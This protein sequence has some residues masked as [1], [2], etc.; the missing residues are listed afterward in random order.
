MRL[1]AA[2]QSMIEYK[3]KLV[4]LQLHDFMNGDYMEAGRLSSGND[5][6]TF[7]SDYYDYAIQ[8]YTTTNMS[9]DEI[10]ELGLQEVVRLRSEMEKVKKQGWVYR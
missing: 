8:L 6:Y 5:A 7:G 1:T 2:Y 10:H 4:Y 9:A 3:V